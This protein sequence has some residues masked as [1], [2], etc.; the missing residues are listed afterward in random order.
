MKNKGIRPIDTRVDTVKQGGGGMQI[1]FRP[2]KRVQSYFETLTERGE[3]TRFLNQAV[4]F[5]LTYKTAFEKQSHMIEVL[6]DQHQD[7]INK[8][9]RYDGK[10][11]AVERN[12]KT[13]SQQVTELNKQVAMLKG[14]TI[15]PEQSK[16]RAEKQDGF[17]DNVDFLG[18]SLGDISL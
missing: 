14:T 15:K 9:S 13:I 8:L 7:L 10:L 12:L 18:M 1:G 6:L 17:A 3:K 11:E 16:R 4:E 2:N 5:T